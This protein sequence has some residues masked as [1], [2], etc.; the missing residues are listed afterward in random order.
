MVILSIGCFPIKE[1]ADTTGRVGTEARRNVED[2][3]GK[4]SGQDGSKTAEDQYKNKLQKVYTE[5]KVIALR[6]LEDMKDDLDKGNRISDARLQIYAQTVTDLENKHKE[7]AKLVEAG[8][9][10]ATM[11]TSDIAASVREITT[12]VG[13]ITGLLGAAIEFRE[14]ERQDALEAVKLN[15]AKW[16]DWDSIKPIQEPQ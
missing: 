15:S 6:L 16:A 13:A 11:G 3:L 10:G 8:P 9:H 2:G 1:L 4:L 7:L 12:L 14:N 5:E